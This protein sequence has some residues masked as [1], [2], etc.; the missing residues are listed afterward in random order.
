LKNNL[1]LTDQPPKIK[2]NFQQTEIIACQ[3]LVFIFCSY[4]PEI[5]CFENH[6]F[7]EMF[8]V[9]CPST[10]PFPNG[11]SPLPPVARERPHYPVHVGPGLPRP[12][13]GLAAAATVA[14]AVRGGATWMRLEG[15]QG[16]DGGPTVG[17]SAASAMVDLQAANAREGGC[18]VTIEGGGRT[19]ARDSSPRG[20]TSLLRVKAVLSK[21]FQNLKVRVAADFK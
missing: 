17:G 19:V 16:G 1:F 15:V 11:N 18:R 6:A 3:K 7:I 4:A 9:P 20:H 13:A 8:Q 10:K 12:W 21:C 5:L 2:T 14:A